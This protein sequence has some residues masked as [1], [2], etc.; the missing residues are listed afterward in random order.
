MPSLDAF[1]KSHVVTFKYYVGV[2]HFL[3]EDYV[4]VNLPSPECYDFDSL[5]H[6]HRQKQILQMRGHFVYQ[7][8]YE[9]KSMS[10]ATL[11]Q[12]VTNSAQTHIDL[13]H[14]LSFAY[15]PYVTNF[16]AAYSFPASA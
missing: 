5:S 2:I 4:Q 3:E 10:I 16:D 1:P 15:H 13:S 9:T 12:R 14:T 6:V 11:R 7:V 8:R